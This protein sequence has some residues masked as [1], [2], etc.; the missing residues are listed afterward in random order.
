[1]LF[2]NCFSIL[3]IWCVF[4]F[5]C[6]YQQC[7]D[8]KLRTALG[9]LIRLDGRPLTENIY[10]TLIYLAIDGGMSPINGPLEFNC[11]FIANK[12]EVIHSFIY[13]SFLYI[14]FACKNPYKIFLIFF[15]RTTVSPTHLF[16]K[17][18][19]HQYSPA[20]RN[21]ALWDASTAD[22]VAK[23]EGMTFSTKKET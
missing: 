6:F 15:F 20:E 1:M 14:N 2:R 22:T 5:I 19:T 13:I 21:W 23:F 18:R 11:E 10:T 4:Y 7:P 9:T 16:W 17:T 8:C 12:I 3:L